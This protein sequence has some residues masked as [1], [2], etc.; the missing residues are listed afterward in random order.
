M[1][2]MG[3]DDGSGD[4]AGRSGRP[5]AS[6]WSRP[7]DPDAVDRPPVM[8]TLWRGLT[9]RCPHCGSGHLFHG[10]FQLVDR[11]PRCGLRLQRHAGQWSGDIGINTVVTFGLLFVVLLGGTLL[12]FDDPNV[13]VLASLAIVIAL[14]FPVFFVPHAKTIWVAIDVV[15]RPVQPDELEP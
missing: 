13:V 14:G 3:R 5:T 15:T 11:C 1:G 2:T 8:R 6:I 4:E 7:P 12:T 9:K 10:Y